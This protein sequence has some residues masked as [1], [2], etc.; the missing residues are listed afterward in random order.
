[1]NFSLQIDAVYWLRLPGLVL[2][3]CVKKL[4]GL[5]RFGFGLRIFEM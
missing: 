4:S 3:D 5:Q 1:M 2:I